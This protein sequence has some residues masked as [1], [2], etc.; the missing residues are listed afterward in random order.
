MSSPYPLLGMFLAYLWMIFK[1]LPEFMASRK[2]YNLSSIIR[3]YN[4]FQVIA[5]MYFVAKF[6][7]H[8][9]SF[10]D[11]WKCEHPR[12][13]EVLNGKLIGLLEDHWLFIFLRLIEFIE[14]AFFLLRKKTSQVSA[15]HI[16]HHISTVALLWVHLKFNGGLMDI[17]IGSLNSCV[18]IIMY[19]YY[20]F[21]S[22]E[23]LTRFT[24]KVKPYITFIQIVQLTVLFTHCCVALMPSCGA[25]KPAFVL[26]SL[27]LGVLILMFLRFYIKNFISKYK[28]RNM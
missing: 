22:F 17:Y 18:H 26:Q 21:S 24:N 1:V 20:F 6:H 10:K 4:V 27:N 2:P 14:T 8:G 23:K 13:D 9:F 11:T 12:D 19:C 28:K 3:V 5:C 16:Y 25:Y 7:E 15:L